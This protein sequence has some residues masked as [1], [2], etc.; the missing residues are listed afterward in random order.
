MRK[1]PSGRPGQGTISIVDQHSRNPRL[2]KLPS[3]GIRVF[4]T[5]YRADEPYK[6]EPTKKANEVSRSQYI[7]GSSLNSIHLSMEDD[8]RQHAAMQMQESG[9]DK[10]TITNTS[11][12]NLNVQSGAR[13]YA[14]EKSRTAGGASTTTGGKRAAQSKIHQKNSGSLIS[15]KAKTSSKMRN[16]R[17]AQNIIL[18]YEQ[19][20]QAS[21]EGTQR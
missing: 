10:S 3:E 4:Q 12:T 5:K 11:A 15:D 7:K 17:K 19:S 14:T 20:Q 18:S 6:L 2:A 16:I 9:G 13:K 8:D 1:T 21:Q